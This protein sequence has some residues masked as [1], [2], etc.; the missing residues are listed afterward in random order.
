MKKFFQDL[1]EQTSLKW[2][3]FILCIC[4][5]IIARGELTA[6]ANERI[7]FD[8]YPHAI[9]LTPVR[10]A[11]EVSKG[12]TSRQN[13]EM[14]SCNCIQKEYQR[15]TEKTSS[16]NGLAWGKISKVLPK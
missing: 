14:S 4:C 10:L 3:G 13:F 2:M 8:E 6:Q 5:F 9:I 15:E 12:D 7:S 11:G 1:H 16:G